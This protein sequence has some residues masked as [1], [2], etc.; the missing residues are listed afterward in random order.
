M[1]F[2]PTKGSPILYWQY[3]S[4]SPCGWTV[5]SIPLKRQLYL[6]QCQ[7]VFLEIIF[8][9]S[10]F[11]IASC[12]NLNPFPTH[13]ITKPTGSQTCH[14][15]RQKKDHSALLP[16]SKCLYLK[17]HDWLLITLQYALIWLNLPRKQSNMTVNTI[18]RLSDTSS[19]CILRVTVSL[20]GVISTECWYTIA[21][22]NILNRL[23]NQIISVH[24]KY[25]G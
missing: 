1:T 9:S 25:P 14:F 23:F 11:F 8:F 2:K 10:N 24:L 5:R 21:V 15:L 7:C 17:A 16:L 12:Y 3:I 20:L 22:T 6:S 18:F 13:T 4:I 19:F